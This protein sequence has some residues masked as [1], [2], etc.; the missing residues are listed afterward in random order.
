MIMMTTTTTTT[1]MMNCQKKIAVNPKEQKIT[2]PKLKTR[3]VELVHKTS[4][5]NSPIFKTPTPTP[6]Q[7]PNMY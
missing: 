6:S 4:E 5:S 7:N 1:M 3:A 2:V